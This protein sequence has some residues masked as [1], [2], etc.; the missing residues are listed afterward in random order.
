MAWWA[1][2]VAYNKE[3]DTMRELI[4]DDI[5]EEASILVPRVRNYNMKGGTLEKKTEMMLPGYILLKLGDQPVMKKSESLNNYLKILGPIS[6][7]EMFNIKEH[8]NIPENSN[9]KLGDKII[10][11][12]GAFTGVKGTV[13]EI[14]SEDKISCRLSFHGND[15]EID[16]DILIVEKI[17]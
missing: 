14:K 10:V 2:Q 16:I 11:T 9:I 8:E 4:T 17:S 15:V 1:A 7:D 13:I 3:Y 5:L 12:H 6:D